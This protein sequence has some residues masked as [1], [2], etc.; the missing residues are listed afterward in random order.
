MLTESYRAGLLWGQLQI[1]NGDCGPRIDFETWQQ[2]AKD[3]AQARSII[4]TVRREFV[5]G[6]LDARVAWLSTFDEP[7][8]DDPLGSDEVAYRSADY[9][10]GGEYDESSAD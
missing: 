6:A 9:D 10:N 1:G 5:N 4:D 7:V 3:E 8:S 2:M